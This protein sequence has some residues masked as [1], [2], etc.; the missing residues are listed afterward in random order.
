MNQSVLFLLFL[1]LLRWSLALLPRLECSG[2]IS[3]HCHLCLPGSSD[4]P[5]SASQVAGIIGAHQH[6]QLIFVFL[7]K[8]G[9][10]HVGQASHELLTL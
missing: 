7:V 1:I 5:A 4:S 3:A 6:T 8:V 9:F 2:T 10:H